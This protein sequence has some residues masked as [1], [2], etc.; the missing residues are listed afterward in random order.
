MS[1]NLTIWETGLVSNPWGAPLAM[2]IR[3]HISIPAIS[4]FY[5]FDLRVMDE[6]VSESGGKAADSSDLGAISYM[7]DDMVNN[8]GK[9]H[10]PLG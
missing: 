6:A 10:L 1:S 5:V 8:N 4:A 2:P 7:F 3:N 9:V